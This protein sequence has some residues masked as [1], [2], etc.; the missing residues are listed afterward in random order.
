MSEHENIA[1]VHRYFEAL[2]KLD[3]D[4]A[5]E[6]LASDF[7]HCVYGFDDSRSLEVWKQLARSIFDAMPDV[8]WV[9]EEI[10]AE[11]DKV[12]ARWTFS[13]SHT[14]AEWAGIPPT[15]NKLSTY[16]MSFFDV[17]GGNIVAERSIGDNLDFWQ[18]F[19][20]LPPLDEI[21]EEHK[22]GHA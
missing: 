7:A 20:V 6:V 17:A 22:S 14:G 16:Y 13:G 12:A 10:L 1:L 8:H 5:E 9:V 19:G 21:I 4:M 18:Q 11:G 15:G 2:N 3:L